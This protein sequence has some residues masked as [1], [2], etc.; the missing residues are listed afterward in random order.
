M[1]LNRLEILILVLISVIGIGTFVVSSTLAEQSGSSPDS[2]VDS[3]L[4]E[5]YD[6]LVG[7]GY[8]SEEGSNGPIWNRIIS[9]S[10]WVP[11]GGVTEGDVK[12]GV[13]FYEGSRSLRTGTL[14][15]PQYEDMSL[16]AKDFRDPN[17]STTWSSWTK[18]NTTPEVWKDNRT[19]LYW[20]AMQGTAN[21]F[22]NEFTS[23]TC[24]F[25]TTTPRG[26]YD[27]LDADCGNA[28]NTC[29][30]LSVDAN[31]DTVEDSNWYL[32]TQAELMQA[33]LNG[34]YLSTSDSWV[35]GNRFWS[36]TEYSGT[37]AW[38]TNLRHGNTHYS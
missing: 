9:S 11:D 17:A 35:T 22:T 3:V 29:G 15:Y 24:N 20:S 23:S 31:G 34:I 4:K 25:Y 37:S 14:D 8:G 12:A 28:I 30:T 26:N 7:S 32:P 1:K 16:Q 21:S 27:G 38:T 18:T 6:T 33:Y 13:G 10:T 2:G 19:G 5:T 36:S